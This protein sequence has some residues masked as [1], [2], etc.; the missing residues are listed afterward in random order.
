MTKYT[1]IFSLLSL[2]PIMSLQSESCSICL[3]QDLQ[4]EN[5]EHNEAAVRG[6]KCKCFCSL[7]VTENATVSNN[8]TVDGNVT[9][10]SITAP[11][12]TVDGQLLV[13][14]NSV[15]TLFSVLQFFFTPV[16]T[17]AC[18]SPNQSIAS[19]A[20]IAFPTGTA[21][22]L[23][24]FLQQSNPTTFKVINSPNQGNLLFT[25][26]IQFD[27]ST[28]DAKI[29]A[30]GTFRAFPNNTIKS[31]TAVTQPAG[32]SQITITGSADISLVSL[33]FVNKSANSA[34]VCIASANVK[35]NDG[36]YVTAVSPR[37]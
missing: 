6:Q 8:L 30:V 1:I 11:R 3:S 22:T 15:D 36:Y 19:Q 25:A 32:Q 5:D 29:A 20:A 34:T 26:T 33:Q 7:S 28:T 21:T 27:P 23:G 24:G 4:Q 35:F 9:G 18:T 31:I 16:V 12:G 14:G 17:R 2:L 37:G 13:N 10:G